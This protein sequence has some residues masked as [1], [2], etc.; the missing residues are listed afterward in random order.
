MPP[1]RAAKRRGDGARLVAGLLQRERPGWPVDQRDDAD[2]VQTSERLDSGDRD[3][4]RPVVSLRHLAGMDDQHEAAAHHLSS[5]GRIELDGKDGCGFLIDPAAGAAL[6]GEGPVV[7]ISGDGG[8]LYACGEL[9]TVEPARPGL[10]AV[11]G[12]SDV[13]VIAV[14]AV[15]SGC[16]VR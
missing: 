1:K 16:P 13:E 7:S 10:A 6:A 14:V 15:A 9:A 5:G 11:E 8:F 12:L 3:L 2:E 4:L